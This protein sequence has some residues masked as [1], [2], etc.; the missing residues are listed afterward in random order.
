MP[1]TVGGAKSRTYKKQKL[2]SNNQNLIGEKHQEMQN[3]NL[4]GKVLG[5]RAYEKFYRSIQEGLTGAR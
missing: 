3:F 1:E 5:W 4:L 2:P